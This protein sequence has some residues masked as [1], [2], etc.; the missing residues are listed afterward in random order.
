M[1]SSIIQY[2]SPKDQLMLLFMTFF[3]CFVTVL[4]IR[5]KS[6]LFI[7]PNE[8]TPKETLNIKQA[9]QSITF[10]LG[11]DGS[12]DNPFYQNA[13]AY[14]KANPEGRTDI[15]VTSAL[16]LNAVF[17]MLKMQGSAS[18][19]RF[20]VI[21][22]VVHSNPWS[23]MSMSVVEDGPRI[24]EGSLMEALSSLKIAL[25]EKW[26]D[27][28]TAIFIHACGLG[29]NTALVSVLKDVFQTENG[30]K[31][32]LYISNYYLNFHKAEDLVFKTEMEAF[33]AFYPTAY[34]PADLHLVRQFNERYPAIKMDWL[35]ALQKNY[36]DGQPISY[37]YNIPV[38]WEVF[39]PEYD[40]PGLLTEMDKMEWLMNQSELLDIIEKTGIPFDDF[41]WIVKKGSG[42]NAQGFSMPSIKVFGK[43]TVVC[44]LRPLTSGNESTVNNV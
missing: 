38:E 20:N 19:M 24:T 22:L 12:I 30:I 33:Y 26:V 25:P 14:F 29:Q 39:Y 18:G 32:Q 23:G 43:V 2:I 16:S 5:A 34:K 4:L 31:P 11:E 44:I 9:R 17:E 13:E 10:I 35:A 3:L 27:E 8:I 42:V 21:N 6:E 40:P 7:I 41:R 28:N 36:V 37:K 1:K 15:V